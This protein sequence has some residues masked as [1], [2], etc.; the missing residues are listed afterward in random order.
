MSTAS[1]VA[2]RALRELESETIEAISDENVVVALGGGA[3]TRPQT[4]E[5]LLARGE[6]ETAHLV[7]VDTVELLGCGSRRAVGN[8]DRTHLDHV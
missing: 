7:L 4:L 8:P 3:L 5:M 2:A 1:R 6:I